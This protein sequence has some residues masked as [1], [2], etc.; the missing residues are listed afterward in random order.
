ML[1]ALIVALVGTVWSSGGSVPVSAAG[2]PLRQVDWAD[3]LANDPNVI[4]DPDAFRPPGDTGPY[5]KV[6]ST[7][8]RGDDVAGYASIHDVLYA[9]LDGDGAEEAVIPIYSGGTAG[10]IGYL[11]YREGSPAP[12]LVIAQGGYKMGFEIE[13]NR[14]VIYEASYVGFEPNC[15]P[16]AVNRTV[17]A[18]EGDHMI[19]VASEVQPNDVQEPTVIGFYHALSDKRFEDAYDFFSP[20]QKAANPFDRWKAGYATTQ[21]IDVETETGATPN[22]VLITLTAVD[23]RQGGGTVIRKFRGA[24]NLIWSAD[25]KRWLLDSAHIE[26]A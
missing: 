22:E 6:E 20:A 16:S 9:D 14:L 18:L 2:V 12:N 7:Q 1:I 23:A 24:W 26:A 25:Q 5:V 15:C 11:V 21:S 17:N 3:V 4:V 19:V 8:M 10:T 13:G